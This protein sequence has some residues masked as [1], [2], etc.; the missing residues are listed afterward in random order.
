MRLPLL[1]LALMT[2]CTHLHSDIVDFNGRSVEVVTAGD[3]PDTV[4]F[5]SGLGDGW[6]RWDR[7]ASDIAV[8]A[9]VFAY[10][11][12]GYGRS[13]DAT[14]PRDPA[15]IVEELRG[16]LA[17]QDIV[18]PYVLVGHSNGGTYLELFAKAHADEVG[19]VVLV[20][21]RPK[22]FLDACEAQDLDACG[23]SDGGLA[24]QPKV[25]QDEYASFARAS[26][27]IHGSFGDYPVRVLTATEGGSDARMALWASMHAELADEAADGEQLVLEGAGH[28]LQLRR[29]D[30][31][32]D[33]IRAVLPSGSRTP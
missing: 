16:L 27:E 18:A 33:V 23:I 29:P 25:V 30:D 9:R 7:V 26:D 14:T 5:E 1:S 20:D 15:Q 11:R 17:S 10:S 12:P 3:G 31:V 28:Y 4:V 8:D 22:D 6:S 24:H 32:S 19:A 21:P 13:D 2:A